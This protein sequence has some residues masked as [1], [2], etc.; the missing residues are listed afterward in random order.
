MEQL[1]KMVTEKTGIS[2]EQAKGAVET[3]LGFLKDKI[4]GVGGQID[5]LLSGNLGGLADMAKD[6][7][8]L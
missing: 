7:L 6:K 4:P 1:I 5:G 2:A 8:G 3:V